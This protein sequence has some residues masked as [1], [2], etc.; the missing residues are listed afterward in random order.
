[1]HARTTDLGAELHDL[2]REQVHVVPRR[3]RRHLQ[4]NSIQG[5]VVRVANCF[6]L[7]R[8]KFTPQHNHN[9]DVWTYV[10]T[11]QPAHRHRH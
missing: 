9:R 7:I 5:Y 6:F 2:L 10:C 1:M 11:R 8:K 3:Q 4:F